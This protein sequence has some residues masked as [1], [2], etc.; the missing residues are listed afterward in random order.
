MPYQYQTSL[1]AAKD[2][3]CLMS[4]ATLFLEGGERRSIRKGQS[5]NKEWGDVQPLIILNNKTY[6]MPCGLQF[7]W[8]AVAEKKLYELGAPLNTRLIEEVW[9]NVDDKGE[10]L[11]KYVAI[12]ITHYGGT[13]VWLHGQKK[14]VLIAWLHAQHRQMTPEEKQQYLNGKTLDDLCSQVIDKVKEIRTIVETYPLP[15]SILYDHMMQQFT[16]K[17]VPKLQIWNDDD[18]KWEDFEEGEGP[19]LNYIEVKRFDGT[20]DRLHDGSILKYHEAG[21]PSH[22]TINWNY[23][24]REYT[25]YF[26]F[27]HEKLDPLFRRLSMLSLEGRFD[28]V[29]QIDPIEEKFIPM[30]QCE[31]VPEPIELTEESV[32]ILVFRNKFECYRSKHYHQEPRAW[33]WV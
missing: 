13:A 17:F 1:T 5:K 24:T 27:D 30:L 6:P 14:Q 7:A 18:E 11:F 26:F 22:L 19:E 28:F 33:L 3:A 2:C 25:A 31:D 15:P 32:D 8:L 12:G 10:P 16:Y 9:N 23:G 20:F 29:L 4:K 21:K